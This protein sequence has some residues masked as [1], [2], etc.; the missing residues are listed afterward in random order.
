MTHAVSDARCGQS[1]FLG[2]VLGTRA[3]NSFRALNLRRGSSDW[4]R[5]LP[6]WPVSPP[7]MPEA[8]ASWKLRRFPE[9]VFKVGK[10][11][12]SNSRQVVIQAERP[13]HDPTERRPRRRRF[14]LP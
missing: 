1:C 14:L 12:A 8:I 4:G 11:A 10:G 9:C 5:S 3:L 6:A 13:W 7:R 2:G